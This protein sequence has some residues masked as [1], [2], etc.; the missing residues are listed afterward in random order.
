MTSYQLYFLTWACKRQPLYFSADAFGEETLGNASSSLTLSLLCT[1]FLPV[2]V[3]FQP[4]QR[5]CPF[6]AYSFY[7]KIRTYLPWTIIHFISSFG[8][9]NDNTIIFVSNSYYLKHLRFCLLLLFIYLFFV[10]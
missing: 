4:L 6:L 7:L 10:F 8:I 9:T 3:S 1:L 5:M 2:I